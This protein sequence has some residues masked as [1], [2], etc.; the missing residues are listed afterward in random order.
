MAADKRGPVCEMG[1]AE[2]FWAAV[3]GFGARFLH[4]PSTAGSDDEGCRP[5]AQA[6]VEAEVEAEAE[7]CTGVISE[8]HTHAG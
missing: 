1:A 7:V 8:G 3:R 6:E 2:V 4:R 5:E